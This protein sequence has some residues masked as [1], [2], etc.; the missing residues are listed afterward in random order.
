MRLISSAF[1]TASSIVPSG[2]GTGRLLRAVLLGSTLAL[3]SCQ[4]VQTTN[5]GTVGVERKQ[6][7]GVSSQ[8]VNQASAKAYTELMEKTRK[9]GKLNRN[10]RQYER[11]QRISRRI[12][13]Q[14]GVFRQDALQ[15]DWEVNVVEDDKQVNA[16]CMAGGKMAV[17]SG[18]I[19]KL[20]PTDDELAAII[21]HEVS[22]ALR[23]H[24]R[25][26]VSAQQGMGA[27]SI[28]AGILFGSQEAMQAT[29][30]ILNVG[31]GLRYSRKAE[32]ESDSMG[33]ELAAR[34]GYDPR[35]AISLWQ[36]M[37]RI[38]GAG[39]PEFLSTH[40]APENRIS[41]LSH[42]AAK[43]MPLYYARKGMR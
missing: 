31:Y 32:V 12:I 15:W 1:S 27:A 30:R 5:S 18:L 38:N 21:G 28:L 9:A 11:V 40:P 20:Q 43:V 16:F 35:A 39:V 17:F 4:T 14:V 24:V 10:R 33:V 19:K 34:A 25:E 42:D 29:S 13:A 22:H 8:S 23:E 2:L 3:V 6:R 26:Q 37:A 7:M 36:K 41:N